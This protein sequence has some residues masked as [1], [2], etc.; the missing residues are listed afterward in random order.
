MNIQ[1]KPTYGLSQR[2]IEAIEKQGFSIGD[3][4]C[5]TVIL[6]EWES[7]P[8]V[9]AIRKAE[10]ETGEAFFMR[11]TDKTK[12]YECEV[13]FTY[14]TTTPMDAANEF[15]A[16]VQLNPHWFVQVTDTETGK[17]FRVDTETQVVEALEPAGQGGG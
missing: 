17:R 10:Q 4:P 5:D 16:N 7:F 15:I 2:M 12:R 9:Q 1:T 13:S 14:D 11:L 6:P 8:I 3:C